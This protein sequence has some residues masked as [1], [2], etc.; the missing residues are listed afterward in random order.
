MFGGAF[1][2]PH[3]AHVALAAAAVQQLGLDHLAV[4]PTGQAWHKARPLTDAAHRTAMARIAFATVPQAVVDDRE[5]RR[6][7]PT[8]TIDTLRELRAQHPQA[9]LFLVMGQDQAAAF[10]T[11]RDWE[12]IAALATLAVAG[13]P[14]APGQGAGLPADVRS[15][16]VQLPPM[17]ESATAIRARLA[18]AQDITPLVPA[19]VASY[20]ALHHLYS[21]T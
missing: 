20:I 1:D 18:S 12:A 19:G 7:G 9:E 4:L 8:Y 14:H 5:M 17:D 13:R 21:P 2:P 6:A 16:A 10:A 15:V 11:W 3:R